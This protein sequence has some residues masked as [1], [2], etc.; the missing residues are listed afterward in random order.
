MDRESATGS[1]N[2]SPTGLRVR[3]AASTW[4][5]SSGS[6]GTAPVC[7]LGAQRIAAPDCP[8]A[9][10]HA[11]RSG[12]SLRT[13]RPQ[14]TARNIP[15][16]RSVP[17]LPRSSCSF[18]RSA[19][20]SRPRRAPLGRRRLERLVQRRRALRRR[21]GVAAGGGGFGGGF[22]GFGGRSSGGR[23]RRRRAGRALVKDSHASE[24]YTAFSE[25]TY[26]DDTQNGGSPDGARARRA[27]ADAVARITTLRRPGRGRS[28]R[29]GPRSRTSCSGAN[30]LIPNL[31]ETVKGYAQHEEGVFKEIADARSRSC[32]ARRRPRR[33]F[34]RRT[35]RPPRS[36]GCSSFVE[37]Y[38]QL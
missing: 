19:R 34:R 13:R 37:N 38:P 10:R 29:S 30:D 28:K 22:G 17:H 31:V 23:W 16:S 11:H 7:S 36:A 5:R 4:L 20:G 14:T 12:D 24:V 2:G 3:P 27:S 33:R 26:A 15:F 32:S 9:E 6:G 8:G 21:L 25:D 18:S 35:S 1:N